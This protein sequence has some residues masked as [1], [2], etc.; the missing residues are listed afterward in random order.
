MEQV[1]AA[2]PPHARDANAITISNAPVEYTT[3]IS[4]PALRSL[5]RSAVINGIRPSIT[6]SHKINI[7]VRTD[8]VLYSLI[9]LASFFNM[10]A[11]PFL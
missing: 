11:T 5:T 6:A 2:M 9:L 4:T 8:G 1:T 7:K 10:K 3:D